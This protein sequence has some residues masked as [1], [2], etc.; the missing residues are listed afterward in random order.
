MIMN[1]I[2]LLQ[3]INGVFFIDRKTIFII[4]TSP[5]LFLHIT[6]FTP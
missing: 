2:T 5:D 4:I 1:T 6:T 3:F